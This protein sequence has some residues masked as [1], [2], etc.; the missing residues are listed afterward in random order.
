M[1]T[2]QRS[3]Q[4]KTRAAKLS[5]RKLLQ[6]TLV[7]GAGAGPMI[8]LPK[9]AYAQTCEARG[10]VQH[11][12]YIRLGGGFRFTTAFNG[13][14]SG[15]F[16]PFGQARNVAAG[17][18]W[19]VGRILEGAE[20]LEGDDAQ[21]RIDLGMR[22]V[23]AFANEMAVLATVDHEPDA[24]NADGNHGTGLDRFNT[25]TLA[26]DNSIFT[27]LHYGL[28]TRIEAAAAD[29]RIELPPFVLGSAGMARGAGQYAA[30]R[31][32]LIQ[33]D[34][35]DNFIFASASLP[36]WAN[37][38]AAETDTNMLNRQMVPERSMVEAYMGTREST[39]RFSEIFASD[40]LKVR[41][42][43]TEM[44]DGISNQQLST[45]FG[46]GGSAN[47]LKLALRLFHFG[48]PAVYLDQ[49]GYDMHSGEDDRLPMEMSGANRL[50]S[51]L[52]AAL[53]RMEHPTGGTYWDHTLV[54]MGSEFGRTARGSGF[55]SA[56]GSD[57]GGDL[58]TRWMS[59]PFMGG[60]IEQRGIGG[61]QFG[62]TA[63]TDLKHDGVVFSYR[64]VA[65]TMMDLLGAD[66]CEF[67]QQD[68][69]ITG[70]F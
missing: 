32:P 40:I 41:N 69:P 23:P 24:G 5:R 20:W 34:S 50:L 67:F 44:V 28:R 60:L 70:V 61:R 25:G 30:F 21:A 35:F 16:N 66:H 62:V 49:G 38:M 43:S 46:D 1:K 11:I 57:H 9:R 4:Q 36:D 42:N 17:T 27:M 58:A 37:E 3:P 53:K 29:G 7:A 51:A 45:M 13:D 19:G 52:N 22:P 15:E 55:N 2:K 47:Q 12:V 10:G 31:P 8:W 68:D 56:G 26:G 65:K 6:S 48:C 33:G 59:M 63:K 39:L 54:V 14:V 64:S 18:E